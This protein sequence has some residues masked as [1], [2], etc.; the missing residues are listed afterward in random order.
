MLILARR[1]EECI[2][3]TT[4]TGEVIKILVMDAYH[5]FVKQGIDAPKEYKILREELLAKEA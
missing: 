4:P 3:I 5:G 2:V 1:K